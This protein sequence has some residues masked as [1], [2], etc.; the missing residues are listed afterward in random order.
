M[1]QANLDFFYIDPQNLLNN[2]VL[3]G[4]ANYKIV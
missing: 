3:G 2:N 1:R 4:H